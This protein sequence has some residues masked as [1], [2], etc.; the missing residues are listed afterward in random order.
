MNA[1]AMAVYMACFDKHQSVYMI[2]YEG[3]KGGEGYNSNM[4]AGSPGYM[5]HNHTVSSE[6]WEANMCQI[7]GAYPDISFTIVDNNV[8]GYPDNYKW[9]KNVRYLTYR[10]FI[11]ELDIGSFKH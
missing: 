7:F 11:Q 9:Y 8:N 3:Q 6:K 4:Y 2:G 1:G 10:E 5:P